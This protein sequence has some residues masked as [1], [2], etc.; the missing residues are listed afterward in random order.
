MSSTSAVNS[1]TS[2]TA[3]GFGLTTAADKALNRDDFLKLLVEQ[4]KNQDP[5]EP[6]KNSDYVAQLAQFSNLEQSQGINDRLDLLAI[7]SRGQSN[8]QV[9]GLVGQQ[10]TVKGSAV[11]ISGNGTGAPVR[12]TLDDK[13]DKVTVTI[14][15]ANGD[16]VRTLDVGAHNAG[17]VTMQWDG[18]DSTGTVQPAG[19]YSIAVNAA[20]SKGS[21]VSV[22][23]NTTATV[24]G[25]SYA[26][27]YAVL[28]LANGATAPVSDLVRIST[29]KTGP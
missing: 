8:A 20:D 2:T 27:G 24:T 18:K 14:K 23:Q 19:S 21:A 28:E 4:M 6:E 1:S 10:A 25:I 13:A 15:N 22:E 17:L 16:T 9:T 7:Q 26:S 12:F 11:T 29:V 5:L 3:Q